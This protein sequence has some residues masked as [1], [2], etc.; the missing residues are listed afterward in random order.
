MDP[1]VVELIV[2]LGKAA[3]DAI[4]AAIAA[5]QSKDQIL[6]AI[7]RI[8]DDAKRIDSDVDRVA[9]GA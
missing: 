4:A 5:G 7:R 1:T 6:I 8:E 2:V 9:Q 3:L